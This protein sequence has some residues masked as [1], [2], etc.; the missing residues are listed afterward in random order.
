MAKGY[1]EHR[2][3]MARVNMLGKQLA[4]RSHS[5][6]ELC[7]VSEVPLSIFE[8]PPEEDEPVAEK[9]LF[10]CEACR[11]PIDN[12]RQFTPDRWHFLTEC[13]W[14]DIPAVQVMAVRLLRRLSKTE[15]WAA[16]AL[17]DLYLDE[18]IEAWVALAEV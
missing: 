7:G 16:A 17:E 13:V 3:R 1:D 15:S 12:P 4:R 9:A 6:C 10:L 2:E 14:S 5:R 18:D 11:D 8:V